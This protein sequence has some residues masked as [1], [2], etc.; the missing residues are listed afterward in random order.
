MTEPATSQTKNAVKTTH[1]VL[2]TVMEIAIIGTNVRLPGDTNG[3][4]VYFVAYARIAKKGLLQRNGKAA[5]L[6]F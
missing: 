6:H 5:V 4:S 3:A 1:M 2:A